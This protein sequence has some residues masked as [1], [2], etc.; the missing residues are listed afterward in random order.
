MVAFGAD[1]KQRI[2]QIVAEC[3]AVE[4]ETKCTASE[5]LDL[6]ESKPHLHETEPSRDALRTDCATS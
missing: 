6:Q 3:K 1:A 2:A 5:I 4:E